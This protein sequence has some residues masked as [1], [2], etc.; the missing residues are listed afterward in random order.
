M[1]NLDHS[2]LG[3]L[4]IQNQM[5]ICA[6]SVEKLAPTEEARHNCADADGN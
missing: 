5:M 3:A 4:Q 2:V 6:L 1:I